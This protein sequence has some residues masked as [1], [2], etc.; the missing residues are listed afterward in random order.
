MKI[1]DKIIKMKNVY[2]GTK[3][4]D[5]VVTE[6]WQM[7]ENVLGRQQQRFVSPLFYRAFVFAAITLLL[8]GGIVTLAQ[9]SKPGEILYPVKEFS[10]DMVQEIKES[11]TIFVDTNKK[12][13]DSIEENTI[14]PSPTSDA[15]HRNMDEK[16]DNKKGTNDKKINT[17]DKEGVNTNSKS[18]KGQASGQTEKPITSKNDKIRNSGFNNSNKNNKLEQGQEKELKP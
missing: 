10:Q 16:E 8:S 1:E 11:V 3:V 15:N 14:I 18:V 13:I 9:A 5:D 17:N 4:S 2:L 6:E 7:L 12:Q